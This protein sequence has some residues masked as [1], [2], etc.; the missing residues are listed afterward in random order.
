MF[1]LFAVFSLYDK[2]FGWVERKIS[3]KHS[4]VALCFQIF[5]Q[6]CQ[7]GAKNIFLS[8]IAY[9]P[10]S[11]CSH[12]WKTYRH[13]L[14]Q[15][16]SPCSK[17]RLHHFQSTVCTI[18][19]IPPTP[20]SKYRLHYFS[21]L[22]SILQLSLPCLLSSRL[23]C[24]AKDIFLLCEMANASFLHLFG[25]FLFNDV[26]FVCLRNTVVLNVAILSTNSMFYRL[27]LTFVHSCPVVNVVW[28]CVALQHAQK[29]NN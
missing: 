16:R 3:E 24:R 10:V 13:D 7:K 21:N 17:Y 5:V 1:E 9:T 20:F 22:R 15:S 23:F 12:V 4:S 27:T 11:N 19:K 26:W 6:I 18:F 8:W 28:C 25:E 29:R 2:I 14:V